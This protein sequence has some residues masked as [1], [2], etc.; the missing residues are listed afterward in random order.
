MEDSAGVASCTRPHR[1]TCDQLDVARRVLA[2]ALQLTSRSSAPSTKTLP[3]VIFP[4][5]NWRTVTGVTVASSMFC[6][7]QRA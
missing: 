3:S 7:A 5:R 6:I 1:V 4:V 2:P